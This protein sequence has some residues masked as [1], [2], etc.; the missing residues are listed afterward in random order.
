MSVY[1]H[2][3]LQNTPQGN[4]INPGVLFEAGPIINIEISIPKALADVYSQTGQTI[5]QPKIGIALIDTGAKK[6]C[7]HDSIMQDLGVSTIGQVM[8]GTAN[9]QRP[10]KLFPAFF[11]FPGTGISVDFTS[12]VEVNLSGQIING[13]QIIA[14]VGR[15]L[16]A[17][18]IFVYNGRVGLYTLAI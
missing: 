14:L 8:S 6:S 16:L 11:N 2:F 3:L 17:N 7:V 12:V 1:N 10:C 18:T 15:D 13:E 5:P 4:T 9:G